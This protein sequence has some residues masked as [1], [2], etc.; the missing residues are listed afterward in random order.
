MPVCKIQG[1]LASGGKC[2]DD[3]V[4]FCAKLPKKRVDIIN[5]KRCIQIINH[6]SILSAQYIG[7]Y[8]HITY[9]LY[10]IIMFEKSR[11]YVYIL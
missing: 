6:F 7:R 11:T 8:Y 2:Y 5:S 1:G 3:V 10:V 9:K 4:H